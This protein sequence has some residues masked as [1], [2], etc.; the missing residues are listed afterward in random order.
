MVRRARNLLLVFGLV[1]TFL[2]MSTSVGFTQAVG[3]TPGSA[4]PG[5]EITVFGD[6]FE[7]GEEITVDFGGV[8]VVTF[9]DDNGSFT[10]SLTIDELMPP[11]MHPLDINGS[12]GNF[13]TFEYLVEEPPS[14][15]TTTTQA[16]TTTT[17]AASTTTAESATTTDGVTT[18]EAPSTTD[19]ATT[20]IS[21]TSVPPTTIADDSQVS[22]SDGGGVP[23]WLFLLAILL[24]VALGAGV[25]MA[26]NNANT[27]RTGTFSDTAGNDWEY[28]SGRCR[29]KYTT[30]TRTPSEG[31]RQV[32][33]SA[34]PRRGNPCTGS[35]CGCVLF[36]NPAGGGSPI[37]LDEDGG[38]VRRVGGVEYSARC[39]KKV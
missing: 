4:P 14:P 36:Q 33:V 29:V 17:T 6:G 39:V 5:T 15:T 26:V 9:A 37:L 35:G 1:L 27:A 11:G 24:A 25:M 38:S 12:E 16:P 22:T 19:A 21:D 23:W 2:V 34:V 20:T 30:V 10:V 13:F 28:C 7:P 32:L 8:E 3:V 18:T 31:G